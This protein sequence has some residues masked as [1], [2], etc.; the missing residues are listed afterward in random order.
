[1]ESSHPTENRSRRRRW[2]WL[3][4][5]LA[6]LLSFACIFLSS[7]VSLSTWPD[8]VKAS[9]LAGERANYSHSDQ[10]D[11]AFGSLNPEVG[12]EAATD[13]AR[14]QLTPSA[15]GR[16]TPAGI[17]LLPPTPLRL[18][19]P[20]PPLSAVTIVPSLTLPPPSAPTS[21]SSTATT[22]PTS[23]QTPISANTPTSVPLLP[24]DTPT[25]VAPPTPTGTATGVPPTPTE[26]ATSVPPT[27]TET[28]TPHSH[29]PTD[30]PVP[31]ADTPTR[32]PT[33]TNTPVAPSIL[34]IRPQ[35]ALLGSS[36]P[37]TITGNN[38]AASVDAAL[39][40]GGSHTLLGLTGS[41]ATMLTA[42]APSSLPVGM[43]TLT[44]TNTDSTNLSDSLA[45]AFQVFTY[46][47]PLPIDCS[48]PNPD[49]I[50]CNYAD[51]APDGQYAG[52]FAPTGVIT[53][54]FGSGTTNGPGY[55]LVFYERLNDGQIPP[56]IALDFVKIEIFDGTTWV[57]LFSWDGVPGDVAGTNIDS[58]AADGEAYNEAIPTYDLY[59]GIPGG[60]NTGIAMD[61]GV[62]GASSFRYIR[63]TRPPG[64]TPT[65]PAEIDAIVRL[66]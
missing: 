62:V 60:P 4:L 6:L 19:T 44:V 36:V 51:G 3:L 7:W 17:A 12:A 1:M 59:P 63:V 56:G 16:G 14:L 43:Y 61:V 52:I 27:P 46:T 32:T 45:N 39:V 31:P 66:N 18:T 57:T 22:Q 24:T 38:F 15:V 20:T 21:A 25:L 49:V 37:V 42:D 48:A 9:M 13:A 58:Y 23:T 41:S 2:E 10:E 33:P 40:L 29:P 26:T 65:E 55:D 54:D 8:R 64:G 53:I 11:V 30:T 28:A 5:L 50:D 47:L 34:T 35:A